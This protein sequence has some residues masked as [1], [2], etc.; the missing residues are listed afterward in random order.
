MPYVTYTPR[1]KLEPFSIVQHVPL[2]SLNSTH[3]LLAMKRQPTMDAIIVTCV[4][5][6]NSVKRIPINHYGIE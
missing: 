4:Q 6:V 5:Y 2:I 1:I 3:G